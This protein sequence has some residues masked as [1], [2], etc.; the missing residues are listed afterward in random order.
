[1]T[2]HADAAHAR[3]TATGVVRVLREAG[4]VA[5]FAGGCVRDELLGLDPTDYDVATDA[6]PERIRSLFPP[7]T[8][9]ADVGASF[10]VILVRQ[11]RVTIEV[12]TF[13]SEGPYSDRRRPDA[14]TFSDA[15]SDA[16]RRDFTVNALFLDPLTP[17]DGPGGATVIDYVG[18]VDDLRARLLRAV[19]DPDARLAEDNLRALRAVRLAARLAFTI[20][21]ATANAIR[22]HATDLHGVSRERIGEEIRRILS[23]PSR[24]SALRLLDELGLSHH[25]LLGQGFDHPPTVVSRLPP[26]VSYPCALAAWAVDRHGGCGIPDPPTVAASFRQ[27]LCLSNEET[28]A[29]RGILTAANAILGD[30]TASSMAVRKREASGRWFADALTLSE[31][32]DSTRSKIVRSDVFMLASDGIGISPRPIL[33]GEDL[34]N[35]GFQPGPG[36]RR[37]LESVYD[38]QLEGRVRTRTEALELAKRLGV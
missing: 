25:V 17:G 21:Q 12:A 8:R 20:E 35:L 9:T 3:R 10:G 16:L 32:I 4:H 7:P 29:L 1:M 5:Y 6:T 14:V 19:G 13:R 30:W 33:T 15:K 23:H 26:D 38:A 18:G 11:A 36:F 22:R 34:I 28:E 24:E 2:R 27:A 31:A 37:V